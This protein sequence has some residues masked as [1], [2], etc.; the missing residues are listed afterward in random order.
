VKTT[1]QPTEKSLTERR[2]DHLNWIVDNVFKFFTHPE[3][4]LAIV[5]YRHAFPK[6]VEIDGKK[7]HCDFFRI[8][9]EQVGETIKKAPTT[10]R[11][12]R[13]KL[14]KRGFIVKVKSPGYGYAPMYEMANEETCKRLKEIAKEINHGNSS[15]P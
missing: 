8:T 9:D 7:V 15:S 1:K 4:V 5:Y 2:W 3:R 6:L 11:D 12:V 13:K 14:E 10:V